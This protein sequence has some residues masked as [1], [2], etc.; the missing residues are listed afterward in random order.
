MGWRQV[1]SI[2]RPL[3]NCLAA[4][5]AFMLA[6]VPSASCFADQK[7]LTEVRS[8]NFRVLTDGNDR[9][10]RRIAREFEEMRAVF[11]IGFPNLRLST[12][13]PLLI[14]AMQDEKSMKA[15]A[16]ALWTDKK[17]KVSGFFQHGWEKQFATVRLDQ[18][19]P[20]AFQVVYH[21]YVHSLLHTNFR[22][23][24]TWLDEGLAEFYGS[25]RFGDNKV[26]VGAPN[27]RVRLLQRSTTIPLDILLTV[28]PRVYFRGKDDQ[29]AMFY[30]ESWAL[31]H[32]LVFAPEMEKGKKLTH[33]SA[34]LQQGDQQMKAFREAIGNVKDVQNRL[35]KYIQA[36]AFQ[37]WVIDNPGLTPD[38]DFSLRKLS[39]AESDAEVASYRLWGRDGAEAPSL[40][41][42]ALKEDPNQALAHEEMGFIHFRAGQDP[43]AVREFTRACELDRQRYLSQ[44][45]KTMMEAKRET[46]EQ[47]GAL[48]AGLLR[49]LEINQQFAPAYVQLAMGEL[50]DGHD[51]KAL[52][53]S[54]K[55]EQLE[56]SRAG[57]HL[58][59]GQILLR[60]KKEQEAADVAKFVAERWHG[61][62]HNEAVALWNR[63]PPA[64]RPPDAVVVEEV[65]EQSQAA[66]GMIIAVTCGEKNDR[67]VTLRRGD[68]HLVFKSQG[69][70]MTG[71]SDTL[72]YGADH[73]NLCYHVAGMHAVVRYRPPVGNEYAGD[74]LSIELRN[75][76]PA[77]PDHGAA[78]ESATPREQTP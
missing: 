55:A 72:W 20:G 77:A 19:L 5:S 44:Y 49:T 42:Q 74:W 62:D 30:A 40:V 24:P 11:A 59:S 3:L 6:L 17:L 61:P 1:N 56:P 67:E 38:K 32:F 27:P 43:D 51:A 47:R 37:S 57:Y 16:P 64:S 76:L 65:Q 70:Q 35:E 21:E 12:G 54:R 36:F 53:R 63:V 33:F 45:F 25:T 8:P 66:E 23:L 71:F 52:G 41:E 15:L 78:V 28:N 29:I 9:Q 2:S 4:L 58:L 31:V 10:A 18:D 73:F 60:M 22:W 14:F 39:K 13:A 69:R 46:P 68:E 48:Q 7:S 50:A 75:E 26:Y 34:L